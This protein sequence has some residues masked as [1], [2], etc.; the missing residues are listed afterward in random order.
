MSEVDRVGRGWTRL[1][2]MKLLHARA[3]AASS[4]QHV[5][6]QHRQVEHRAGEDDRDDAR[7]V[8]L[9]RDVGA[10]A[11]VHA[12]ADDPLGELHRDAALALLDEHD[13]HEEQR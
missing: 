11:A 4:R 3:P 9:Q 2:S 12:A 8:D 1:S 7:L 6:Q 10:L 5:G 13:G